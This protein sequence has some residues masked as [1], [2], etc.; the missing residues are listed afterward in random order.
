MKSYITELH[1]YEQ[2][3]LPNCSSPICNA[4]PYLRIRASTLSFPACS[5]MHTQAMCIRQQC[6]VEQ[7]EMQMLAEINFI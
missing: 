5:I 3:L 6:E 7:N 2:P 4:L 1:I